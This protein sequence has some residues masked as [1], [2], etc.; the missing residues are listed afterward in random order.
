VIAIVSYGVG[1]VRAFASIYERA[2]I[3]STVASTPADLRNA[4]HLIL[5]GVGSF[6]WAMTRLNQSGLRETLDELVLQRR[7]P[8]LGVC[9]GM[10]MMSRTSAEGILPGLGW[11]PADVQHLSTQAEG[12]PLPHMGWNDVEPATDPL[13][14]GMSPAQFYFLHSFH[15]V[16][17][18]AAVIAHASYGREFVC[19]V[20]H[21]HIA[22]VQFHPEKSHH[23]GERLLRNF[24]SNN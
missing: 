2:G 13:F 10:Q 9:V 18:G 8:V 17:H 24:A 21:G 15:V 12:L 6:D 1:N 7:I 16:P 14:E 19:A 5:P 20:R 3:P 22:G 4:T 11:I 23:W